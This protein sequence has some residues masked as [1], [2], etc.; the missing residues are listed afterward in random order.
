MKALNFLR[1][2]KIATVNRILKILLADNLK[3]DWRKTKII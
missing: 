2:R 3:P 1:K